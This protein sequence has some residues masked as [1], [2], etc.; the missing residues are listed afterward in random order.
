[1]L[2]VS[3]RR[4]KVI[5]WPWGCLLDELPQDEADEGG[6]DPLSDGNDGTAPDLGSASAGVL[7]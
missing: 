6:A 2:V 4:A 7:Q 3:D 5:L 1:V